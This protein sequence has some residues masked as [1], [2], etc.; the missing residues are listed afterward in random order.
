MNLLD[1]GVIVFVWAIFMAFRQT[2]TM[3][4]VAF[5]AGMTAVYVGAG[6]LMNPW[7]LLIRATLVPVA[8]GAVVRYPWLIWSMSRDEVEYDEFVHDVAKRLHGLDQE[9]V[10][11]PAEWEHLGAEY[12]EAARELDERPTPHPAWET[13]RD[14]FLYHVRFNLDVYDGRRS[15]DWNSRR[16]SIANWTAVRDEWKRVRASRSR[17]WR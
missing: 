8:V 4:T 17:F 13:L 10:S 9:E 1:L 12:R 11:D 2:R 14:R 7:R 3:R 15:A 16:Q 6:A 5:L